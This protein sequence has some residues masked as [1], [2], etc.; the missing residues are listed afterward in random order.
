M[1]KSESLLSPFTNELVRVRGD[2]LLSDAYEVEGV[3]WGSN[4]EP[5]SC[6]SNTPHHYPAPQRGISIASNGRYQ[7]MFVYR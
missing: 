3:Q 5:F 1:G 4:Q 2:I 6:E 7:L